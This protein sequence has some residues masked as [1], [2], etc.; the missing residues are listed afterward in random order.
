MFFSF[1]LKT[2]TIG[3]RDFIKI[4]KNNNNSKQNKNF[5]HNRALKNSNYINYN[6][7]KSSSDQIK[8][9]MYAKKSP[10]RKIGGQKK[11]AL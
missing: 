4:N 10:I 5:C 7:S 2:T 6:I 8:L 3:L 9:S 1:F 11:K